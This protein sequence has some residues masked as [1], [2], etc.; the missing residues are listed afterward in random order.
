MNK[1]RG[2]LFIKWGP[3]GNRILPRAIESLQKFHPE[4]PYHVQE[5]PDDSTL[6]NKAAMFDFSPFESTLFLDADVVVLG[7][8]DYA[9]E[10]AE[11][12]GI[13]ICINECPWAR[14]FPAIDGDV[15]EYNCG[16]IAFNKSWRRL[17]YTSPSHIEVGDVS[18]VFALWKRLAPEIDSSIIFVNQKDE[19]SKMEHN[20]QA[21]FTLALQKLNFN[22]FVLP[23]NWNFRPLWHRS[24]FGPM[25]IWHSYSPVPNGMEE[26]N[27]QHPDTERVILYCRIPEG[28]LS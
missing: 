18:E 17:Y 12:F 20:D 22:P 8:L 3:D 6:L 28:K 16:V 19:L 7:R 1:K 23:V 24:F 15:I 27:S 21:G 5:L 26:W 4:L 10:Q 13:A 2:V 14:R 9:F 25:K 11:K